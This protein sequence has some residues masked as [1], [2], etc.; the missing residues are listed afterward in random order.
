MI[1]KYLLVIISFI[2]LP[3]KASPELEEI[4]L[5]NSSTFTSLK[6]EVESKAINLN[7]EALLKY[8]KTTSQLT[9]KTLD[10]LLIRE[11]VA[12]RE[13]VKLRRLEQALSYFVGFKSEEKLI[14]NCNEIQRSI[15]LDYIG[16]TRD[17][18]SKKAESIDENI[19]M[20]SLEDPP[21]SFKLSQMFCKK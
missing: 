17:P 13:F 9:K 14:E 8:V 1:S 4:M 19:T 12:L 11:D 6:T 15:R 16:R 7:K 21:L 10:K 20:E 5:D 2:Y 3:C 18:R